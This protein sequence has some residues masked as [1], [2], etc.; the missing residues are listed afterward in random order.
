MEVFQLVKKI[1][2][3]H[4]RLQT[5]WRDL[6]QAGVENV[7]QFLLFWAE[8]FDGDK[9]PYFHHHHHVGLTVVLLLVGNFSSTSI[10]KRQ[11][12]MRCW[13]ICSRISV[14]SV[15]QKIKKSQRF[16]CLLFPFSML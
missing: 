4:A 7:T 13:S 14:I 12:D 2:E 11:Y 3:M 15:Q 8:K 10:Y 1:K 5:W 9:H 6:S 16:S